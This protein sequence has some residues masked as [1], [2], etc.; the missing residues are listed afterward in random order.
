M[1]WD[2]GTPR[3]GQTPYGLAKLA[4]Q[5]LAV[6]DIEADNKGYG[7]Y[8][9][10]LNRMFGWEVRGEMPEN[11]THEQHQSAWRALA[12]WCRVQNKGELGVLS[13]PGDGDSGFVHVRLPLHHGLLRLEDFKTLP[14][15]FRRAGLTPGEEIE[16]EGLES[17]LREHA[18]DSTSFPRV[19][20]HRVLQD[21]RLPLA[22]VQIANALAQWDGSDPLDLKAERKAVRL[23]LSILERKASRVHGGLIEIKPGVDPIDI[24]GVELRDVLGKKGAR[25]LN[26]R[27]RYR[28][29]RKRPVLAV[30]SPLEERYIEAR[31]F[32][33]GDRIVIA[34]PARTGDSGFERK[35]RVVAAGGKVEVVHPDSSLGWP[36]WVVFQ[37]KVRGDV[38]A[39]ELKPLGLEKCLKVADPR[40]SVSGGR[41]AGRP[42]LEGA[43]PTLIVLN[44]SGSAKVIVDGNEYEAVENQLTPARCP[45][46]GETGT[47]E[48]W[49]PGRYHDHVR[50]HVERP[51]SAA[52]AEP[53]AQAEPERRPS[54]GHPESTPDREETDQRP[55]AEPPRPVHAPDALIALQLA[56]ALRRPNPTRRAA[57]IDLAIANSSHP[58]LL[59]RQLARAL[60][61]IEGG[62]NG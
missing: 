8:W 35:L 50:F 1:G 10:A 57:M 32:H 40:L 54:P 30:Y 18:Q 45:A 49:I 22:A 20:A 59:V 53:L 47:H 7:G 36:G 26:S 52:P 38:T 62:I 12:R 41:R 16:P 44:G 37:L 51:E 56:T 58:N 25:E 23:W 29:I 15:F 9:L 14:R 5:V 27:V 48:A 19:H 24:P 2:F 31:G 33:P 17:I 6:F 42:W 34:R 46:L 43:G 55:P 28:P 39:T 4:L 60:A 13:V 11:L 21:D 3:A 61:A